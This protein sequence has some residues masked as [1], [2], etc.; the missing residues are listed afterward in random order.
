MRL[1]LIVGNWKMFKTVH[2]GIVYAKELRP[3]V[4]DIVDVE[5]AVAPPFTALH[6]VAEA[7]RTANVSVAG[8][9]I[10]WEPEGAFTG[11]VSAAMVKEAGAEFVI[12]GHSERRRLFGETNQDVNRKLGAA[13]ASGLTAIVCVGETLDERQA[14]ETLTVLDR[15]IKEGL[16]GLGA[17]Q[18]ADLVV[19][20]EPVWAIGTG[21]V[22]TPSQ[23]Q[24][25][26]GH[27]R[28]RLRQS[29]GTDAAERCHIVYGGSVKPDN[30]AE[31]MGCADVDGALV[32]SGCL[33]VERF[34]EIVT[35]SRH[36]AV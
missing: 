11:A 29:F 25:A 14:D 34:A 36:A 7:L 31:L 2:E 17:E 26:H 21:R 13:L 35:R 8:Q 6:A 5:I 16:D 20:Y 22:A 24:D 12:L 27:I 33:D 19:A 28:E 1:P 3:L 30:I 23:A 18:V 15:Q 10:Y 4:K 32:G 9:D